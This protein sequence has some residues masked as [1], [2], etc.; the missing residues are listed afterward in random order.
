MTYKVTVVDMTGEHVHVLGVTQYGW[1][2]RVDSPFLVLDC[3]GGGTCFFK[4][5]CIKSVVISE[6]V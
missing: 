2:E 1:E 5:S 6:E 3:V 4:S